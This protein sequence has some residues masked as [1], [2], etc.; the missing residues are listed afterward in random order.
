MAG[1]GLFFLSRVLFNKSCM[2]GHEPS[3]TSAYSQTGENGQQMLMG[4]PGPVAKP[5]VGFREAV[6]KN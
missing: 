3:R 4:D 1:Q 2:I 6:A 5:Y